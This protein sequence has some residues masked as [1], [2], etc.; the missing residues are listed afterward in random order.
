MC[1]YLLFKINDFL[2]LRLVS[3]SSLTLVYTPWGAH[4]LLS[5]QWGNL[6]VR[7]LA[8]ILSSKLTQ[9]LRDLLLLFLA[10]LFTEQDRGG[11]GTH[12]SSFIVLLS[13]AQ[14]FR[15]GNPK[16]QPTFT[17]KHTPLEETHWWHFYKADVGLRLQCK[18]LYIRI[19]AVMWC[20][21][22]VLF[23]LA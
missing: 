3:F 11:G 12:S 4:L 1:V 21:P 7:Y 10:A 19:S 6:F 23:A 13:D 8:Q 15:C 9:W 22:R 17:W 2:F 14:M 18:C 16:A 20:L 5:R